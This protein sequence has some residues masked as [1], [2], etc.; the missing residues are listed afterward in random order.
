MFEGFLDFGVV[1]FQVEL[2]QTDFVRSRPGKTED[3]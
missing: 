1:K 2:K 3:S